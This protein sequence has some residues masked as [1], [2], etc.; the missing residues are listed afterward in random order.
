LLLEFLVEHKEGKNPHPG[1][2]VL[3]LEGGDAGLEAGII[4]RELGAKEVTVVYR[5]PD[6]R[7]REDLLA[8]AQEEG[9]RILFGTVLTGL[10]GEEG[11]LTQVELEINGDVR[12]LEVDGIFLAAGRFPE[13][14]YVPL[15]KENYN[16]QWLTVYPYASP[17][18][19]EEKGLFRPGEAV[20]DYRAVVEAIGQ[21]RRLAATVNKYL[22]GEDISAPP[23]MIKRGMDVLDV[24]ELV[25][26]KK[27]PREKVPTRSPKELLN[28]LDLEVELTFQEEQALR[29]ASRCLQCGLICYRKEV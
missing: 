16:G 21:G 15:N 2:R 17:S 5:E 1:N 19:R 6:K 11:H 23:H 18:A 24:K 9:V 14:V 7:L 26:I 12:I 4:A 27:I 20:A 25:P 3:I 22:S 8:R 29:E 28:D 13:L 10:M